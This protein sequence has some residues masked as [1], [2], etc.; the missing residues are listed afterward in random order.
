MLGQ[1]SETYIVNLAT[2]DSMIYI[3]FYLLEF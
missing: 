3:L 1:L 2:L